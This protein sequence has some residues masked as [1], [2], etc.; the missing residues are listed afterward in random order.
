M[1][2]ERILE[3]IQKLLALTEARGATPEEAASAA[4]KAQ[5][6]LFE[7]NLSMASVERHDT[8][9]GKTE[10]FANTDFL[11]NATR[12]S[13]SWH[14]TL[15]G[16]IASANF[17]KA[18][19]GQG[20][21]A[22]I[23]GQTSNVEVVAYLYN[24]LSREIERLAT[25]GLR[26]E[27]VLEHRRRWKVSFCY[28]A[29]MTIRQRL[30]EQKERNS[31]QSAACTALV[32]VS[33]ADLKRA[34]GAFFPRLTTLRGGRISNSNGYAAGQEAGCGMAMPGQGIAS[35]GTTPQFALN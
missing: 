6:L 25:E 18:V 13:V 35:R 33:D 29:A 8:D 26:R 24:Y 4:A 11:M 21:T 28:G 7:H 5:S 22:H 20:A 9:K 31:A 10:Q 32:V 2:N 1:M 17:C 23:I 30:R 14:R 12:F 19:F 34:V 27:G 16:G 15:L 3:R